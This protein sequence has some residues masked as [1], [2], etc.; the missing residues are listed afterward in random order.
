MG[1]VGKGREAEEEGSELGCQEGREGPLREK[2]GKE[3]VVGAGTANQSSSPSPSR[4]TVFF[5]LCALEM[6]IKKLS[7][8]GD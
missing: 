2:E 7:K 4:A 8:F 1:R 5:L 3:R 6:V